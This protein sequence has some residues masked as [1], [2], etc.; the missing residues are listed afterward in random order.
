M[1]APSD[2]RTL[3]LHGLRLKGF[4]E[5]PAVAEVVGVDEVE[6]KSLLA[7]LA[8]QEL[9]SYREGRM[10]GFTLT[11]AG[12]AEHAQLLSD[13]LDRHGVREAVAAA[14]RRFLTRNGDLLDVCT[15]W[16]LRGD[17]D[18]AVINDHSDADYD[19]AVIARLGDIDAGIQPVCE[20]LTD[21]LER[22]RRYGPRLAHALDRL[23]GG[24]NDWFT[25]PMIPS[26]HTIWFEL[27]EDL[28][29]TLGI[30][31]GQEEVL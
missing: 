26:Y 28:L 2:P 14:Y 30:E 20:E 7:D 3:V 18:D 9:A 17:G 15:A 31:R 6:A 21:S 27:H 13:E 11:P 22:Y 16:Q 10:S 24:D 1:P 25:K 4:A 5:A 19:A 12:R 8:A 23:R 29:A